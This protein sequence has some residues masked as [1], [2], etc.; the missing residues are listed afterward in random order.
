[1][2][3]TQ[4]VVSATAPLS[5]ELART[6]EQVFAGS[7]YEIFG[8]TEAGSIATRHTVD[9][10]SWTLLDGM[11]MIEQ[12][13]AIQV[14]GPQ[15]RYAASLQDQ[16]QLQGHNRFRFLGRST[17]MI[18][19]GGKRA[20][21]ADLTSKLLQLE[22]VSDGIVF[23]PRGG[24]SQ[25]PAA[26]VVSDLSERQIARLLAERIDPV[27]VPRP[28]KKVARIPRNETGKAT[29]QLLQEALQ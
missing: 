13:G 22:G 2:P 23:M 24:E 3:A 5:V 21:L 15:L 10:D 27:L 6:G 8:C 7:V 1:M 29:D 14:K 9:E 25:R 16:L 12:R 26:L 17:D 11:S 4:R 20:S 28:L 19:V 18:N